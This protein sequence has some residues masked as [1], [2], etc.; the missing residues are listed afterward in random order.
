M[1]CGG[2]WE[3]MVWFYFYCMYQVWE[4]YGVLD[5]EYWDV[6]VD[7]ILV[8]FFGIEFDCKVVYVVW[9]IY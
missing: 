7:Q 4:F 3:C 6:V 5:E 2:L 1:G 8:V 9:G